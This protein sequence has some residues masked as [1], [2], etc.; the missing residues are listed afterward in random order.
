MDLRAIGDAPKFEIPV[1]FAGRSR[2]LIARS[3]NTTKVEFP[4]F[5]LVFSVSGRWLP[6][7]AEKMARNDDGDQQNPRNLTTPETDGVGN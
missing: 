6:V 7:S 2:V 1:F 4:L 3:V 5:P